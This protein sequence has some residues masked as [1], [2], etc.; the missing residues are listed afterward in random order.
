[1]N[2]S[3]F[4][5]SEKITVIACLV[6]GLLSLSIIIGSILFSHNKKAHRKVNL[7][8]CADLKRAGINAQEFY[9][10]NKTTKIGQNLDRDKNGQACEDN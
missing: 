4:S 6:L 2:K 5:K 10:L 7:V 1:M 8:T 9:E 3:R